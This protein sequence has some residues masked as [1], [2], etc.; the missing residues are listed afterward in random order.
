MINGYARRVSCAQW[1]CSM[2]VL[3][4]MLTRQY[5]DSRPMYSYPMVALRM[6]AWLMSSDGGKND[7]TGR[8]Y[9]GRYVAKLEPLCNRH[10]LNHGYAFVTYPCVV[11]FSTAHRQQQALFAQWSLYCNEPLLPPPVFRSISRCITCSDLLLPIT[12]P[13]PSSTPSELL[14]LRDLLVICR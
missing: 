6:E 4:A 14:R 7:V 9:R 2:A 13:S 12:P 10:A 5:S 8:Y 1:L 11:Y 3:E